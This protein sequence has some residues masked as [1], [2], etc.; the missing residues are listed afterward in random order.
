MH[1][2]HYARQPNDCSGGRLVNQTLAHLP[3]PH[4]ADSCCSISR[5]AGPDKREGAIRMTPVVHDF[6]I[7]LWIVKAPGLPLSNLARG[8]GGA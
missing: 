1:L 2:S 8:I 5:T 6:F 4:T 7:I 3:G